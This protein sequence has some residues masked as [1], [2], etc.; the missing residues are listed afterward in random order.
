ML[1]L[2]NR[3]ENAKN[4]EEMFIHRRRDVCF[5]APKRKVG[6]VIIFVF[7]RSL[8]FAFQSNTKKSEFWQLKSFLCKV[9]H[10]FYFPNTPK[11]FFFRGDESGNKYFRMCGS[12][13]RI[14]S[15]QAV[16]FLGSRNIYRLSM[17]NEHYTAPFLSLFVHFKAFVTQ[18]LR[19]LT[20]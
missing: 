4:E 8:A 3:T 14:A 11:E 9:T 10:H 20:K 19:S 17:A 7:C 1:R 5:H 6:M 16:N 12:R 2:I 13:D 15:G 18:R